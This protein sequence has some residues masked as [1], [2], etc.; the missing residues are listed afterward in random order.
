M[1]E[2]GG[3]MELRGYPMTINKTPGYLLLTFVFFTNSGLAQNAVELSSEETVQPEQTAGESKKPISLGLLLGYGID[4]EEESINPFGF[5]FGLRGGYTLDMGLYLGAQFIYFMG[6]SFEDPTT[7]MEGSIN[8]IPISIEG[9][10]DIDL[11]AI[12]IR[13]LLG[14]GIHLV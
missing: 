11:E 10:Y 7:G 9:G 2:K 3:A 6:E 12:V 4:L 8:V 5:G 13:P 1:G 14:L